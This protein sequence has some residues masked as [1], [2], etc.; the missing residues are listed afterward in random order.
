MDTDSLAAGPAERFLR[1]VLLL[2]IVFEF[3]I[4]AALLAAFRPVAGWLDV[5]EPLV[6]AGGV[7]FAVA[8]LLIWVLVRGPQSERRMMA[9]AG[10]NVAGGLAGWFV[11]MAAWGHFE[12][13]GRWLL[14]F[15][16]D[17]ALL[18]GVAEFLAL[19]RRAGA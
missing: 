2:D 16:A 14:G 9:L 13:E 8:G 18:I 15:T 1:R 6:L 4:A 7:V 10:A 3:V 12:G 19:R 17:S 11:L 5:R